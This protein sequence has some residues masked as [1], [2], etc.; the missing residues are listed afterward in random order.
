MLF[1]SL[2]GRL[3]YLGTVAEVMLQALSRQPANLRVLVP[4]I[5]PEL[6]DLIMSALKDEPAVRPS[7][8]AI[9]SA[10]DRVGALA[11]T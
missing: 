3:P 9:A 7:V 2:S 10:L 4:G 8:A 11:A 6:A 1:R 5:D